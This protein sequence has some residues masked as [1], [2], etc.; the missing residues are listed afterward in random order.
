M[1]PFTYFDLIEAFAQAGCPMCRLALR[2]AER[3]LGSLLYEYSTDPEAHRM[4]RAGRGLCNAHSWQLTQIM[5]G[6]LS[7]AVLFGSA[8]LEV[9]QVV[10][11]NGSARRLAE[12]LAPRIACPA[13][14]SMRQS[15]RLCIETFVTYLTEPTFEAAWRTC[16][17]LCLPH[18]R[19]LLPALASEG[20]ER[21]L[22][23]QQT[24]WG[25]LQ[26]DL[27][28][29]Q[30]SFQAEHAAAPLSE[31]TAVSWQRCIALLTGERGVFSAIHP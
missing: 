2:D 11:A 10:A 4:V 27:E 5:G 23:H 18:V 12:R 29:F 7:T 26:A 14:Q 9:R 24:V 13:C 30:R 22:S 3:Y 31:Q 19:L 8:L 28:A 21:L 6:A 15:E 17:G 20:I 1:R 25:R 16:D